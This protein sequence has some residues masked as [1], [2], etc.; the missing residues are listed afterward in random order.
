MALCTRPSGSALLLALGLLI[1]A[2]GCGAEDSSSHAAKPEK[3]AKSKPAP[4]KKTKA[5]PAGAADT[6]LPSFPS[7]APAESPAVPARQHLGELLQQSN[8][9]QTNF[10]VA[11]PPPVIDEERVAAHGIRKL[12]G[13]HVTLYTDLPSQPEVDELPQVF[14]LAVPQ[15]RDY[16]Q[17]EP[18]KVAD[19]KVWGYV[20]Q[21][22]EKFI[23]AGLLPDDLPDFPNG[24]QRGHEFWLYEQPSAYYRRHL[25]LHEGTHAAMYHW[26]GGA[27]PPWYSEG[28]AELLGTHR[29]QDGK[30][31]LGYSPRNKEEVPEWGRVRILKDAYKANRALPLHEV[32]KLP[33]DAHKSNDAYAWSWAACTFFDQHP[34]YQE[35]FRNLRHKTQD[36][37]LDF[38]TGLLENFRDDALA[39]QTEW[40][41]FIAHA[42]YGY[43][44]ARNALA[45]KPAAALPTGGAKVEIA[46]DRGWQSTGLVLEAGKT[47]KLTASGRYSL[48]KEPKEWWCEPGGVTIRY[49][50]GLPLGMLVAA[51]RN[52]S[53]PASPS[54]LLQPTPIG[55]AAE[56]TPTSTGTLWLKINEHESEWADNEGKVEVEVRE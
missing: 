41:L 15:W 23:A 14:D 52:D 3:P 42:E 37:S 47:Y 9:N 8:D 18:Q 13:K 31:Q 29:W 43:D 7:V 27:G 26:L 49:H 51:V 36:V 56:L 55:L 46:A 19:W 6:S 17:I 44:V 50:H 28:M 2:I 10:H 39:M 45:V 54:E 32:L 30:L 4:T 33:P 1:G 20:M 34:R 24:Y 22:K 35:A 21:D 16:F 12:V 40:Q 53:V 48:G 5:A 11:G 38:T 25:M